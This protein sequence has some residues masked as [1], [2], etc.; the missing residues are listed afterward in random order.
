MSGDDLS[1]R[2]S[3]EDTCYPMSMSEEH[4]L[5]HIYPK[6]QGARCYEVLRSSNQG[7]AFPEGVSIMWLVDQG[8]YDAEGHDISD[9]V[10]DAYKKHQEEIHGGLPDFLRDAHVH[11]PG[12]F[13]EPAGD[14]LLGSDSNKWFGPVAGTSWYYTKDGKAYHPTTFEEITEKARASSAHPPRHQ[15]PSKSVSSVSYIDPE[16]MKRLSNLLGRLESGVSK[17]EQM[18]GFN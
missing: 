5:A 8:W 7:Y 18:I 11:N 1:A 10:A 16:T 12:G 17:L 2:A 14:F 15:T 9:A 4:P 13:D 3:L 6:L